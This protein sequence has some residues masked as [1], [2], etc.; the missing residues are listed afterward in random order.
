LLN[1][2]EIKA[3]K[4]QKRYEVFMEFAGFA[5]LTERFVPTN[6]GEINPVGMECW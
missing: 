4:V 6:D 5:G 3:A 2:F 1:K